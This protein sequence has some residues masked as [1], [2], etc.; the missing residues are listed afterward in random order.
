[1]NK[2][3]CESCDKKD[4]CPIYN[5]TR[6]DAIVTYLTN[7]EQVHEWEHN[8]DIGPA[9][10]MGEVESDMS[11]GWQIL[12]DSLHLTADNVDH[13]LNP[14]ERLIRVTVVLKSLI[15]E[16]GP[17]APALRE[18]LFDKALQTAYE[19][20]EGPADELI[21]RGIVGSLLAGIRLGYHLNH[22]LTLVE[23]GIES[24]TAGAILDL[25][26][27]DSALERLEETDK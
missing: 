7:Q 6:L 17:L 12:M 23:S 5:G 9:L 18:E 4:D 25:D 27:S 11:D 2:E 3:Q 10:V 16:A 19:S 8:P 24:E 15:A 22:G 21:H 1:M 14:V 13:G 26:E 20:T